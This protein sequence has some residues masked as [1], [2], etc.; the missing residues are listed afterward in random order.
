M[1]MGISHLGTIKV[2]ATVSNADIKYSTDLNRLNKFKQHSNSQ[3]SRKI[4][5]Q[6]CDL[7]DTKEIALLFASLF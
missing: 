2:D 5:K 3:L 4:K 6:E 1:I 7:E